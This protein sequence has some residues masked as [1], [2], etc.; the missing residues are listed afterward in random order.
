MMSINMM[1]QPDDMTCGPTSLHA[2][3]RYFGDRISLE[4]VI[5][6]VHYLKEGGTLGVLLACHALKRG[7]HAKIY[8]YN[9]DVFDP[10]WFK[11]NKTDIIHKLEEQRKYKKNEK[12]QLAVDAHIEFLNLGGK[13]FTRD[14]SPSLLKRFFRLNVPIL[15]GL[16]ATYLYQSA[17][18]YTNET[19]ETIVHDVLGYPYGHF[20]VLCGYDDEKK[21][22]VVADPYLENPLSGNNYYS[23]KMSRLINAILL[24]IVTYDANLLVIEPQQN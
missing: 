4:E 3:Y 17:R 5:H 1:P 2:V 6:E 12:L 20:V 23:V 11:D 16:S 19:G 21:H 9:L 18:E 7:Y 24:G 14:L 8:N 10:T 13:I 22:V 15:A